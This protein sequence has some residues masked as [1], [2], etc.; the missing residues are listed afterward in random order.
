MKERALRATIIAALPLRHLPFTIYNL[1]SSSKKVIP[2]AE[3][4]SARRHSR[5]AELL[6]RIFQ[7]D[8]SKN[9]CPAVSFPRKR[10]STFAVVV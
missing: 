1:S 3:L 8:F 2:A 10:E 7:R 6:I 5:R 9:P 4:S